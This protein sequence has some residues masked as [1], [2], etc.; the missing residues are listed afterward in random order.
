MS[1]RSL[2]ALTRTLVVATVL[3]APVLLVAS[4]ASALALV[5]K[6][7]LSGSTLLIE[8]QA[9]AWT[10]PITVDG[11]VMTTSDAAGRYKISRSGYTPPAD[12]TVDVSDGIGRPT[13]VHLNGCTATAPTTAMLPD[14]AELGPFPVGVPLLTTLVSVPGAIGPVS[15]RITAG[16][17]PA[18]L[19]LRVPAPTGVLRDPA[20]QQLT[21]A[22][23]VGTPTAEGTGTVTFRATD[24]NGLT[25]T[26]TYTTRVTPAVPVSITPEPWPTAVA[27][28]FT[29]LW[30]DGAGGVK[31]YRWAVAGGAL[32]PGMSLVQD[33]A[34]GPSVRVAG[35]PTA[36][37]S[38]DWVLRLTDAQ[39][40]TV[41]R[42]FSAT[43]ASAAQAAPA[44]D[45]S[46]A[47]AP[48]P[49]FMSIA[50]LTLGQ[51]AVV[52]GSPSTGTVTVSTPAP[53]G[54]TAVF[55]SSSNPRVASVPATVSVPEGATSAT[56]AVSTTA[57]SAATA[58]QIDAT[59]AG[60][61]TAALSVT[62]H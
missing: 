31:P 55:L 45:P 15:W 54:G 35:T 46:P 61:L 47:P 10:T 44:P 38:Y 17:L 16:A 53:A 6:A 42:A 11:V 20:P 28:E 26:R 34:A 59:Y 22:E 51:A 19:S 43:V 18:G 39:G 8:G 56:F 57:V 1:R 50:G 9:T 37:G 13:T 58:V 49:A 52:G 21:Y 48:A 12:C 7:Q 41:T 27:G 3:A 5:N 23:I 24:A 14:S 33:V 25:V 4:P 36:A 29:N 62:A 60:T 32:P 40:A 30:I 2:S